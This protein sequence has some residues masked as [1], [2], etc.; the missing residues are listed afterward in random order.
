MKNIKTLITLSSVIIIAACGGGVSASIDA[1][2]DGLVSSSEILNNILVPLPATIFPE[3][4]VVSSNNTVSGVLCVTLDNSVRICNG[5]E[6]L[7][8]PIPTLPLFFI[9]IR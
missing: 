8:I 2:T 1:P 6:G 4:A 9:T 3:P 5:T 7:A